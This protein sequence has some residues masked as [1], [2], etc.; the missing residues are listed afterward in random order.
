MN[1][2]RVL[3]KTPVNAHTGYGNDGIALAQAFMMAG[4]DVFLDPAWVQGP[5]PREVALLLTRRLEPPFDL[6][7]HHTDPGQ[8]GITP[9]ARKAA[10]VTIAHTM[11]EYTSMDN[12]RGRSSLRS[13][14]KDYD[15]VFAYDTVTR[16]GLARYVD[17]ALVPVV[18]GGF[19]PQ[20]WP[21][22]PRDWHSP[23][24]RFCMV[25]AL[26]Q[27]KAPF[28]AIEAFADLKAEHPEFA[29]AELHL[30]TNVPGLHSQLQAYVDGLFIHYEQWPDDVLRQFY[31]RMHVLLAPSRGEG[32][33]LPAL[34]FLSTGGTVIAT[35]FAGHT[36]WLHPGIG[37]P[38]HF[39]LTPVAPSTPDCRYADAD[40]GHLK[41]LMWHCFTHRDEIAAKGARASSYIADLAAWDGV[42][43]RVFTRI[44][45]QLPGPGERLQHQYRATVE[46]VRSGS[47]AAQGLRYAHA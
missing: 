18:Q 32:K 35:N 46:A 33:N 29:S 26:H 6:L 36:Q 9:A 25:G 47:I 42:L 7:Y 1:P 19:W 44:A 12:C 5:L 14:L 17:P 31:S 27:R 28:A 16:D 45:D 20:Q 30:K 23:P 21:P 13:R 2:P 40:I 22:V 8:L 24:L 10:T 43:D 38:L 3:L 4:A 15:L 34:G 39:T 11:W 37:Y 41:Q